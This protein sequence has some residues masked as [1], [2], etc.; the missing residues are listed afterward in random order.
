M[1]TSEESSRIPILSNYS[2]HARQ[3]DEVLVYKR[4]LND[5]EIESLYDSFESHGQL[6]NWPPGIS[7]LPSSLPT[8]VPSPGPTAF[9]PT[10]LPTQP[11][12]PA[13]S[14]SD[15]LATCTKLNGQN[16]FDF[17]TLLAELDESEIWED[18]AVRCAVAVES[19]HY[20]FF[21]KTLLTF[22]CV[23]T[24]TSSAHERIFCEKFTTGGFSLGAG[25]QYD[26][27]H[28]KKNSLG[29]YINGYAYFKDRDS[30][31]TADVYGC[32]P[33]I[34]ICLG[35]CPLEW[36][37]ACNF[38]VD[39]EA[40][41]GVYKPFAWGIGFNF[42]V[43]HTGTVWRHDDDNS[44]AVELPSSLPTPLPSS[45]PTPLPSALP[46]AS[47]LPTPLPSNLPTPLPR[48]GP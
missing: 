28:G 37:S 12:T 33:Q 39:G 35:P 43:F 22:A 21:E 24:N 2:D 25:L 9:F 15:S 47:S 19:S 46:S 10:P 6:T 5:N 29:H 13:P 38:Y 3:V 14:W 8:P 16:Q 45:L 42:R 27:A 1:I 44:G 7:H 41:G 31:R 40:V 48:G 17:R 26:I 34:S 20:P 18:E 36:M 32:S 23:D 11:P 4:A 30:V